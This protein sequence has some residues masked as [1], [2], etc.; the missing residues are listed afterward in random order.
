MKKKVILFAT[1]LVFLISLASFSKVLAVAV[2]VSGNAAGSSNNV[3]LNQQNTSNHNQSNTSNINN[4]VDV[5]CNT[6]G[7]SASG[8]TGGNVGVNTGDCK[9]NVN[10]TNQGN[11]N[12]IGNCVSPRPGSSPTPSI[13][14]VGGSSG[15]GGA[16]G[17]GGVG[18]GGGAGGPGTLGETGNAQNLAMFTGGMGIIISGLWLV[19][20]NLALFL[21]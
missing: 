19:R 4:N 1:I 15:G 3:N 12:C 5:N 6:G 10:I 21:N 7:N 9:S 8:N 11:K 14:P 20:R 13:P 16:A 2:D 17:G 18:G